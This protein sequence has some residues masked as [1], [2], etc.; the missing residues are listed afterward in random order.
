MDIASSPGMT[1]KEPD[2]NMIIKIIALIEI[3]FTHV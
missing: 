1:P 3:K 2:T